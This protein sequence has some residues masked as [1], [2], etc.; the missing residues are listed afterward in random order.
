MFFKVLYSILPKPAFSAAYQS[1]NKIL[2][3]FRD[4]SDM[5]WELKSLLGRKG[6]PEDIVRE[7]SDVQTVQ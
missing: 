1:L 7:T 2:C 4:I 6:W 3:F 5:G